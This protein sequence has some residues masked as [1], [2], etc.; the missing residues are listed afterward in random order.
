MSGARWKYRTEKVTVDENTVTVRGLTAGERI[1]FAEFQKERKEKGLPA[2]D[3]TRRVAQ[4][5]VID[6]QLE[7]A[8]LETMPGDLLDAVVQKIMELSGVKSDDEKDE[9]KDAP[10][11]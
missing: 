8:D 7:A 11:H 3:I 6:P 1:K 2:T 5:G 10:L 9:K 4:F